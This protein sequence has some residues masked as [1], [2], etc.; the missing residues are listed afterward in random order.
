MT[1]SQRSTYFGTLWPAACKAQGWNPKDE[2]RRRDVTHAATGKESTSKLTQEQIT[3]LFNKLKWL[4]DPTNFDLAMADANPELALAANKRNN[5]IWR[6]EQAAAGQSLNETYLA[7]VAENKCTAH[8]VKSWRELP[9]Q[10]LVNFS[11]T[12]AARAGR[13]K[14]AAPVQTGCTE[15]DSIPF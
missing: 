14:Q 2:E 10:E 3:L 4:A 13:K 9:L 7:K 15:A 11:R 5:V 6:I 8:H 1:P 12:I